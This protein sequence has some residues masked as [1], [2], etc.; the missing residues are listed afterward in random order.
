MEKNK[1]DWICFKCEEKTNALTSGQCNNCY[2]DSKPKQQHDFDKL[3]QAIGIET[4]IDKMVE[5]L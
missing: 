1:T 5:E 4:D 3:R 2:Y